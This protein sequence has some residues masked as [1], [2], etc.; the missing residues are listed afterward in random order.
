MTPQAIRAPLLP[1]GSVFSSSAWAWMTRLVPPSPKREPG[2]PDL[3][4]AAWVMASRL[5]VP[6][7]PTTRLG[8]SPACEPSGLSRPCFFPVGLKC[9][10]ADAK[11]GGSHLAT[12]WMCR[13]FAPG[14][15]P[16]A[17]ISIWTPSACS[18]RVA[19]PT[20]CPTLSLS[21]AWARRDGESTPRVVPAGREGGE[22]AL[23]QRAVFPDE[24]ALFTAH[25]GVA[26]DVERG[27]AKPFHGRQRGEGRLEPS[28]EANL[29]L[30][31]EGAQERRMEVPVI[32][33]G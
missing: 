10:P 23:D 5:A 30:E 15:R 20:C 17:A 18:V 29:P 28:A 21:T 32:A 2:T 16:L 1:V 9:A 11:S 13:P 19:S 24:R 3:S 7:A 26:E 25:A 27:A 31:P 22:G 14:G 4:V 8:R 33:H 6:S 12:P